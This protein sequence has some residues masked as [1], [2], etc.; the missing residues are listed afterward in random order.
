MFFFGKD[1]TVSLIYWFG[2]F[3]AYWAENNLYSLTLVTALQ[4]QKD[5]ISGVYMIQRNSNIIH[6]LEIFSN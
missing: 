5:V 2:S 1:N 4:I 3:V 6:K